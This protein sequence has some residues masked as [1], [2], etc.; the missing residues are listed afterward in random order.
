VTGNGMRNEKDEWKWC[1]GERRGEVAVAGVTRSGQ[2]G[3]EVAGADSD[4]I[5]HG[6]QFGQSTIL[7]RPLA[8]VL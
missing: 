1:W 2:E 8:A 3:R 7:I 4:S 5:K 6:L